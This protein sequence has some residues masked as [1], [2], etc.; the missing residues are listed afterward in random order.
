MRDAE[1]FFSDVA[2]ALPFGEV[3]RAE[4]LEELRAHVA[5]SRAELEDEGLASDAAERIAIERLGEPDRLARALTEARRSRRRLVAAA[6][7][8]SWA[9]VSNGIYGWIVG[10]L[11]AALAWIATQ[12]VVRF[13]GPFA[14]DS[15]SFIAIGVALYVAGS[16]VTPVVATRAGYRAETVRRVLALAGALVLAA[17]ALVGWSGPLDAVGVAARLTLPAWWI[18]GI[19]RRSRVGR[20]SIR[21]FGGLLLVAIVVTVGI[22]VAQSQLRDVTPGAPSDVTPDGELSLGRIAAPAPAAIAAVVTGQGQASIVGSSG[23]AAGTFIVDVS[24]AT[25]LSAWR[26]LRVEAWRAADPG[27]GSPT[28][29]SPAA[30]GP[31]VV[32]PAVWSPPGELPGGGLTWSSSVPWGPRAMTLSGSVRLDGTPWVTAGWVALTGVAP[33]GSRHLIAE[34]DYVMATFNGTVLGWIQAAVAGVSER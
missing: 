19:S 21:T 30:T 5:D 17:Y 6:G 3:E 28:P 11:I 14:F 27:S 26:D 15:V 4:I 23:V 8:G 33:D 34:P 12:A 32:S 2:D 25:G 24:D 13:V 1:A 29:V 9:V 16:V 18:A 20:G 31:F 10:V 7:A 22:Q